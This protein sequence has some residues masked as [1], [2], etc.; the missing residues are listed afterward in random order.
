MTLRDICLFAGPKSKPCSRCGYKKPIRAEIYEVSG[1]C[2]WWTAETDMGP[3]TFRCFPKARNWLPKT[4]QARFDY[5]KTEYRKSC[6]AGR[7][8]TRKIYKHR[9]KL[10]AIWFTAPRN[11]QFRRLLQAK[12]LRFRP[13]RACEIASWL[14]SHRSDFTAIKDA[15]RFIA[16]IERFVPNGR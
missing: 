14:A 2:E 1:G 10:G 8:E 4:P 16:T 15:G 7:A 5:I 6:A 12:P 9:P 13:A 3:I 11:A